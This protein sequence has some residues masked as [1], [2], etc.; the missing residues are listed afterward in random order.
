MYIE[1][2]IIRKSKGELE[3][4]KKSKEK[5]VE[6]KA[7]ID[8]FKSRLIIVTNKPKK[9][10]PKAIVSRTAP[11]EVNVDIPDIIDNIRVNVDNIMPD[12][13]QATKEIKLE[14]LD[15]IENTLKGNIQ[16]LDYRLFERA[17]VYRLSGNPSW[18]KFILPI[19]KSA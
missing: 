5:E 14:V 7:T 1:K 8:N 11:I 10:I 9:K 18:K 6:D 15:F 2:N 3:R 12:F 16:Q 19:L 4:I 17:V 13:P